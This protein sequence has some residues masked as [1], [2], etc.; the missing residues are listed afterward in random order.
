VINGGWRD[1]SLALGMT[2]HVFAAAPHLAKSRFR[3]PPNEN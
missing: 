2:N 1:P 3:L